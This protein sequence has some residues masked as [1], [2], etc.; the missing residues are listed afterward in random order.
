MAK[1]AARTPARAKG[2]PTGRSTAL[3]ARVQGSAGFYE[4][5]AWLYVAVDTLGRSVGRPIVELA[6]LREDGTLGDAVAQHPLA[7]I[8]RRPNPRQTWRSLAYEIE[9]WKKL[10][11]NVFLRVVRDGLGIPRELWPLRPEAVRIRTDEVIGVAS[12]EVVIDGRIY[13]VRLEDMIHLKTWNPDSAHWGCSVIYALRNDIAADRH[14]TSWNRNHFERGGLPSTWFQPEEDLSAQQLRQVRKT[15]EGEMGGIRNQGRPG[16]L[17]MNLKAF[18]LGA[19]HKDIEWLAGQKWAREKIGTALGVPPFLMGQWESVAYANVDAQRETFWLFIEEELQGI[20]D[21]LNAVLAP[22]FDELFGAVRLRLESESIERLQE[23]SD[24]RT[25]RVAKLKD[26]GLLT[27]NECREELGF[28]RSEIE[29]TDELFVP[30]NMVTLEQAMN[31]PE[32]APAGPGGLG[33]QL[34]E[35][36][37]GDQPSDEDAPQQP[38]PRAYY[39]AEAKAALRGASVRQWEQSYREMRRAS[40]GAVSAWGGEL[41][42]ALERGLPPGE[43]EPQG[44]FL[45]G[46]LYEAVR[47]ARISIFQRHARATLA[48][49][50]RGKAF[51]DEILDPDG[52]YRR[53]LLSGE[54]YENLRKSTDK[55]AQQARQILIDGQLRRA[56]I[57]EIQAELEAILGDE[58][59]PGAAAEAIAQTETTSAANL[60]NVAGYQAAGVEKKAWLTVGLDDVRPTHQEQ[61]AAPPVPVDAR[62]PITGGDYPGDP[63]MSAAEAVNCRCTTIPVFDDDAQAAAFAETFTKAIE[64]EAHEDEERAEHAATNGHSA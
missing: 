31:P 25:E 17:P 15:I 20:L 63:A 26:R 16:V 21:E 5:A 50:R 45:I 47:G 14:A 58:K 62:F 11:G 36:S 27:I 12:Y 61:E 3:P 6:E 46:P 24:R 13:R 29:G 23:S 8:M 18:T 7:S 44:S 28:P 41:L 35:P 30:A 10:Q 2:A 1:A 48:S 55:L 9:A 49:I 22:E 38:A 59:N 51:E 4:V 56:S 19:P 32:P 64:A 33:G 42:R 53:R 37:D 39:G 40:Q 57:A 34:E 60:G 54:L 52:V 43:I